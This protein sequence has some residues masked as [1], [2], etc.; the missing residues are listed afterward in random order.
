MLNEELF[1]IDKMKDEIDSEQYV[2]EDILS[3]GHACLLPLANSTG[4]EDSDMFTGEQFVQMDLTLLRSCKP[5][6][7]YIVLRNGWRES[8]GACQERETAQGLGFGVIDMDFLT[9][10]TFK[11]ELDK[12]MARKGPCSFYVAGKYRWYLADEPDLPCPDAD[13]GV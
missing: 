7:W 4:M 1:D 11:A 10:D 6:R 13:S 12:I 5:D 3:A 8:V 2:G 9:D